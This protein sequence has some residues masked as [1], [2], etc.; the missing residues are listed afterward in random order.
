MAVL[1]SINFNKRLGN[2]ISRVKGSCWIKKNNLDIIFGQE[3]F[4]LGNE[5]PTLAGWEQIGG[6]EKVSS[7]ISSRFVTPN[8]SLLTPFIQ[9]VEVGYFVVFNA[10]LDAYTQKTRALQ[11]NKLRTFVAQE[12]DRPVLVVG[13][14]N[15]APSPLDGL[16][17]GNSSTFNSDLDRKPFQEFLNNCHLIDLGVSANQ[18]GWTIERSLRKQKLQFR[19]DLILVSDYVSSSL[20]MRNDTS[21][22]TGDGTFTDHSGLLIT[23]PVTMASVGGQLPLIPKN[24]SQQPTSAPT[25]FPEK[26]AIHR[27]QPTPIARHVVNFLAKTNKNIRILDY[28]CGYGT[29]VVFYREMGYQAEGYDTFEP[30][31]WFVKPDGIFEYVTVNYVLN[32]LPNRWERLKLIQDAVSYLARGG[33][34]VIATRSKNEIEKLARTNKWRELN[35]GYISSSDK[36]TFQHGLDREEI[37]SLARRC[38]LIL[39]KFDNEISSPEQSTTAVLEKLD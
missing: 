6:N 29:D 9:R 28:G 22:R 16:Y 23:L 33:K 4:K 3:P 2:P 35:D 11:L 7:W 10:Y 5:F 37:L 26:T 36:N 38:G 20:S 25:L 8:Q 17:G 31:G 32:V 14:F 34:L 1:A 24:T 39:S 18:S 13:D 27:N 30:F 12:K 15:L 19:C 21:T